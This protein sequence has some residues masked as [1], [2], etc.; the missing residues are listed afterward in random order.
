MDIRGWQA[1]GVVAVLAAAAVPARA[2]GDP[3]PPPK[4]NPDYVA[5]VEAVK[6]GDWQRAI[7]HLDKVVA[8]DDRNADAY[9]FLGYSHRRL[10]AYQTALAE[11]TKALAI[12]PKHRGAH[13]YIGETYLAL[14]NLA[15]AREHLRQLD[16]LCWL[17]CP[18]YDD[19]K[20]AV[21]SYAR[22]SKS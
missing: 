10:G 5:G 12:D 19:L 8:R 18:E 2:D 1:L 14:G 17:G 11:Y 7:R 20:Q 9:N 22:K 13:E 6:A 15:K 21:E 3:T 4:A 16:A